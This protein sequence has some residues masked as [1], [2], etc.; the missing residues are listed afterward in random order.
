MYEYVSGS[1]RCSD[2]GDPH[3]ML[4][5]GRAMRDALV[6]DLVAV[7]GVATTYAASAGE[8]EC[9]APN[10]SIARAAPGERP[11]HFVRRLAARSDWIWVVAPETTGILAELHGCCG[12]AGWIGC[13]I[14]SIGVAGSKRATT[15]RLRALGIPATETID[16]DASMHGGARFVVKPDD[17]A[18]AC[19]TRVYPML[20]DALAE[21]RRRAAAGEAAIVERWEE[22]VPL[23]MSL[24]CGAGGVEVLSVNRQRIDVACDG[25]VHYMGVDVNAVAHRS[26]DRFELLARDI[27][28]AL[29][30]L[31]GYVGVDLVLG[32][33]GNVIVVEV[34]P[35]LTCAYVGLS[36][37][38]GRNVARDVLDLHRVEAARGRGAKAL[39]VDAV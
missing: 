30:G 5:Q 15:A 2:D 6:A 10:A 24:L 38:L 4:A 33:A 19:D 14:A 34:N 12:S 20:R 9:D 31:R 39:T 26:G 18:G 23:S 11:A 37:A 22:G 7:E 27:V 28:R 32:T 3:G 29:P 35:R 17:G 13:D 16:D 36:A 25:T 21:R 1:A 8:R